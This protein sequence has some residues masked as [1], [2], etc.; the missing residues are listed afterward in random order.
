MI[1]VGRLG[2]R[3]E[4]EVRT[5]SDLEARNALGDDEEAVV[6]HLLESL[7]PRWPL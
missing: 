2:S 6:R 4:D 3:A 5:R 7:P 1:A